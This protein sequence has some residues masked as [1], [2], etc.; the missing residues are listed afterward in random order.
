MEKEIKYMTTKE[1]CQCQIDKRQII[2]ASCGNELTPI[3]TIDNAGSPTFW[4]GCM[5]CQVFNNVTTKLIYNI[6]VKMV[7]ER[8]FAYYNYEQIPNKI[9][10]PELFDYWRKGQIS[11]T[12][13]A[14]SY[15]IKYYKEFN[16][17]TKK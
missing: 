5:K 15:I 14:V 2:C 16:I 6:A 7:D 10:E 9:E 3:E 17:K 1:Q 13:R 12:C 4:M 11:G 8:N